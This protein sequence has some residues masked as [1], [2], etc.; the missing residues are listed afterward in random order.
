MF[1]TC[2]CTENLPSSVR[3]AGLAACR[4][5]AGWP[6]DDFD[7]HLAAAAAFHGLWVLNSFR[8]ADALGERGSS[9]WHWDEMNFDIPSTRQIIALAVDDLERAVADDVG[10]AALGALARSLREGL[11][12]Q[13]ATWESAPPHPAFFTG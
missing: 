9:G 13:W 1:P 3:S 8:M 2:W 11:T 10:L 4:A 7:A 5:A 6:F 12:Q